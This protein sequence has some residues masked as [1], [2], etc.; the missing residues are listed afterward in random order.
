MQEEI[1]ENNNIAIG[2]ATG[3]ICVVIGIINGASFHI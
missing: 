2:I 1:R 3:A